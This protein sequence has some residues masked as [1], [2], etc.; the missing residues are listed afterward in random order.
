MKYFLV[1]EKTLAPFLSLK[2][3]IGQSVNLSSF[4][5]YTL[6]HFIIASVNLKQII[7][8]EVYKCHAISFG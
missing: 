5:Q 2:G 7:H 4:L 6:A 1:T 3:P 8:V